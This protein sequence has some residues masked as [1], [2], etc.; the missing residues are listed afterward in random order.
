[1]FIALFFNYFLFVPIV[2]NDVIIELSQGTVLQTILDDLYDKKVINYKFPLKFWM[3]FTW[4]QN[5]L[6]IGEYKIHKN[7]SIN[8]IKDIITSGRIYNKFIT[9]PEGLTIKQIVELLNNNLE[10]A[11]KIT[12]DI[13]EGSLFPQT[14]A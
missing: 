4:N 8:D 1:M 3:Y 10:I 6:K 2:K 5:Q 7:S 11:G 12:T 13:K 9:I 14:Y